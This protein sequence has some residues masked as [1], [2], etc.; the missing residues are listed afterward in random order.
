MLVTPS[1]VTGHFRTAPLGQEV[2]RVAI[3][4]K[5]SSLVQVDASSSVKL[6]DGISA[7][8]WALKLSPV[9]CI[10]IRI[11]QEISSPEGISTDDELS[12]LLLELLVAELLLRMELL[13]PFGSLGWVRLDDDDWGN[14]GADTEEELSVLSDCNDELLSVEDTGELA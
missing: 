12:G 5:D 4:P 10:L 14:Q 8:K 3:N 6:D 11:S 9:I 1:S 2:P 13:L 7:Q